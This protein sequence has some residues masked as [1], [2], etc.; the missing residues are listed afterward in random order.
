MLKSL[1]FREAFCAKP[2]LFED[3]VA[4]ILWIMI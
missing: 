2:H 4:F 3:T 1:P